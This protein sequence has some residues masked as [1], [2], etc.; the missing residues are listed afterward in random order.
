[1]NV[2]D[3]IKLI[4]TNDGLSRPAVEPVTNLARCSGFLAGTIE[5]L[6]GDITE[7]PLSNRTFF[8][9]LGKRRFHAQRVTK[10][11]VFIW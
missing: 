8:P 1:M 5:K 2:L 3:C 11:L 9:L 10:R 6:S 4:I 7:R